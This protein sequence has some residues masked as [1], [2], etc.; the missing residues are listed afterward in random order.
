MDVEI[1]LGSPRYHC[2]RFGICKIDD[3]NASTFTIQDGKALAKINVKDNKYL[4]VAFDTE[5]ITSHTFNKH[6]SSGL[7]TISTDSSPVIRC[8][9]WNNG[10]IALKA[11][12]YTILTTKHCHL[13]KIPYAV[14]E[15][16]KILQDCTWCTA[17]NTS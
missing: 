9:L 1:Q 13:V 3:Y 16:R 8:N 7:F 17:I 15:E 14:V 5:S 4:M 2:D 10:A 11:G 12:N 6:F